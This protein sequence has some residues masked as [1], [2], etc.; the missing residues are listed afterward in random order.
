MDLEY[1]FS[2]IIIPLFV[3][4]TGTS[5]TIFLN[6]R[7][8]RAN[9]SAQAISA[10]LKYDDYNVYTNWR[11][12]EETLNKICDQ[13]RQVILGLQPLLPNID[14]SEFLHA[15]WGYG[16][17]ERTPTIIRNLLTQ[18]GYRRIEHIGSVRY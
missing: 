9:Y 10:L 7:K 6:K 8:D 16:D 15:S 13:Q 14:F 5:I 2:H 4:I 3:S 18:L 1:I 11:D 17:P 12:D